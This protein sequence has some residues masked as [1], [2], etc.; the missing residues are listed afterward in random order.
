MRGLARVLAYVLG[1][2]L[3]AVG[4]IWIVC[5]ILALIGRVVL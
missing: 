3:A 1:G 2:L 5:E 4:I